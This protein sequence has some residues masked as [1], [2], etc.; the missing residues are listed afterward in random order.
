MGIYGSSVP[1]DLAV[2][3]PIIQLLNT[4]AAV[5]TGDPL[6]TTVKTKSN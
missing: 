6:G 5:D 3:L 2:E 4:A 1:F